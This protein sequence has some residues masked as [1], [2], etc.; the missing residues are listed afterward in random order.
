MN[1]TLT[2]RK[3]GSG[4]AQISKYIT[5]KKKGVIRETRRRCVDCRAR[6]AGR[7]RGRLEADIV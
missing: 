3:Q 6:I 4:A 5:E 7:M 2:R 1:G